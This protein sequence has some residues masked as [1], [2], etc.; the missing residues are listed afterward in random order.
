[1]L[2][3]D[4]LDEMRARVARLVEQR[5]RVSEAL[6][7]LPVDQWPSAANFILFRP[8]DRS[9]DQVW[10][11]LVD[12]SVLVRNCASWPGLTDCLRITLGTPEE[13]DEFLAALAAVLT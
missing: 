4:H 9:G 10:Q 13:N 6:A 5:G 8:H 2:A 3:L 7:E 1:V 12:R 11:E